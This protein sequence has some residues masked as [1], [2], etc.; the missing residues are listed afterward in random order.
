MANEHTERPMAL[1]VDGLATYRLVKLVRDDRITEPVR[2]AVEERNGPPEKSKLT[3]LLSCPWCLSIYA[4]AALTLARR[5][6]PVATS[7]V[8]R[9][10]ALSALTGLA[11]THLE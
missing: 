9:P 5:R 2:D 4:G 10:L 6:W 3:Y 1:L 7:L 11:T 8:A